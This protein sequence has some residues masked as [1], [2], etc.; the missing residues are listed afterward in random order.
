MCVSCTGRGA[1]GERRERKQDKTAKAGEG[2]GWENPGAGTCARARTQQVP[3]EEA[4]EQAHSAAGTRR[5]PLA[6]RDLKLS[7]TEVSTLV[8]F[9]PNCPTRTTLLLSEE[10]TFFKKII[11]KVSIKQE[12][13]C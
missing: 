2:T 4:R 7:Q 1:G 5:A 3:P 13:C 6:L 11:F 9:T 8:I 10:N 12:S